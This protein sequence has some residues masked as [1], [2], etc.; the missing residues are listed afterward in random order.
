MQKAIRFSE[1]Q[2]LSL[3]ACARADATLAGYLY[4]RSSDTGKWQQRWFALYQN[5]L[6]YFENDTAMRP[7][8]LALIE[9]CQC[10]R[11]IST[12]GRDSEKQLMRTEERLS[13]ARTRRLV[14]RGRY[15]WVSSEGLGTIGT[16]KATARGLFSFCALVDTSA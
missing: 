12:K 5:F 2:L 1:G 8:G 14:L 4:K 15:D 3:S 7:S 16:V 13:K 9:G 6:F 11:V 10:E